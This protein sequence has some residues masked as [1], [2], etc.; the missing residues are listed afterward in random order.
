MW[1]EPELKALCKLQENDF[2]EKDPAELGECAERKFR[3]ALANRQGWVPLT[4]KGRGLAASR[5]CPELSDDALDDLRKKL[6]EGAILG[7]S[8]R[9]GRTGSKHGLGGSAP[10]IGTAGPSH[11]RE[12]IR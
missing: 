7:G 10:A 2:Q 6:K 3:N 5:S 4:S 1:A 8:R 9:W 12:P 11:R